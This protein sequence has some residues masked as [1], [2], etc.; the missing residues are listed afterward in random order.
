MAR[1][2][3]LYR[4]A[5]ILRLLGVVAFV[6]ILVYVGT[7]AY[8][9]SRIGIGSVDQSG[10]ATATGTTVTVGGGIFVHNGG[11]LAISSISLS[12]LVRLPSGA[13]LGSASSPSVAIP[14]GA[15]TSVPL[16]LSINVGGS[17]EA[18]SLLTHSARLPTATFANVTFAGIAT[19][20]VQ[21]DDNYSWG[22]PFQSLNVTVGPVN[23]TPLPNGSVSATVRISFQ[24]Q[25]AFDEAGTLTFSLAGSTGSVCATEAVAVVAPQGTLFDRTV[26][27]DGPSSC[28]LSL[29]GGTV[30]STYAGGGFAVTLPPEGIP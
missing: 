24:N 30:T 7:A 28:M 4:L 15:N 3:P 11:Y 20:S 23:T 19:V 22:A 17:A 12:A 8:S 14:P 18:Q 6:L 2:P 26:E 29:S 9:A 10:G 27:I 25:A 16:R 13:L 1:R 5:R 21:S